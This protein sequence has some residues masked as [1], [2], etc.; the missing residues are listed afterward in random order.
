[1]RSSAWLTIGSGMCTPSGSSRRDRRERS[2][3]RQTRVGAAESK[4]GFLHGVIRFAQRPSIRYA[5]A[6]RRR[7]FASNCVASQSWSLID[8]VPYR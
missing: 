1:M 2:M 3:F 8:G 6:R 5:T 7:R 4:P